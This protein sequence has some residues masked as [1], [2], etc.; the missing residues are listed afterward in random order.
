MFYRLFSTCCVSGLVEVGFPRIW[1]SQGAD[2]CQVI[3]L[4]HCARCHSGWY[5]IPCR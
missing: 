5:V 2:G 4:G 3:D 1:E